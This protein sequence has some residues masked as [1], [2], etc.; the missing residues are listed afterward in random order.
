MIYRITTPA[1]GYNGTILGVLFADG[2]AE[3]TGLP[4]ATLAY[5]RRH[6][7]TVEAVEPGEHAA[8]GRR[9]KREASRDLRDD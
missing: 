8:S 5:F 1:P 4:P 7:Y 2:T 3:A 6:G 9:R